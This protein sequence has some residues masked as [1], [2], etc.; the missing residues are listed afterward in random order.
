VIFAMFGVVMTIVMCVV[1][2]VATI[3]CL[4]DI[5]IESY[6]ESAYFLFVMIVFLLLIVVLGS[7]M[8]I[9]MWLTGV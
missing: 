9:E 1:L 2:F 6:K 4:I 3:Y 5:M 8:L 7:L